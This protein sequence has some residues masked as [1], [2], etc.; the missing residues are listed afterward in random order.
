MSV[1]ALGGIDSPAELWHVQDLIKYGVDSVV[2]GRA[3]F[4][5]KFPCQKIWRLKP[6]FMMRIRNS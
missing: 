6:K 2:I 3:I 1:T 5:N 4:E